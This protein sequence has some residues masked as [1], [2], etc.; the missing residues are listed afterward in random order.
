MRKRGYPRTG[1]T[2]DQRVW[3]SENKT[4]YTVMLAPPELWPVQTA[5]ISKYE[6]CA[7]PGGIDLRCFLLA[8]SY[9]IT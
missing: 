8:G 2:S 1:D 5:A 4:N 9:L 7:A 6:L 3:G